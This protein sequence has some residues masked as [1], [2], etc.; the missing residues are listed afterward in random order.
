MGG[1]TQSKVMGNEDLG[2]AL[3]KIET[4]MQRIE[5]DVAEIKQDQKQNYVSKEAYENLKADVEGLQ[6][7]LNW[8][9]RLVIGAVIMAILGLVIMVK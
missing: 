7:S 4:V 6:S 2:N 3:V 5:K 8:V 1:K 9:T